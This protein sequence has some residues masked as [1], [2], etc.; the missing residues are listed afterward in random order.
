VALAVLVVMTDPQANPTAT[1]TG[2]PVQRFPIARLDLAEELRQL[3]ASPTTKSHLAKTVVHDAGLRVVLM[4]L[5]RGAKIPSHTADCSVMI[6]V[7]DGRVVVPLF[8]TSYDL[9]A[10]QLL[11]IDRNV[12]HAL[13]AIEDSALMLTVG[14]TDR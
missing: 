3:R 2:E 10:G 11:A 6:H 4:I 14:R 8:A 9:G 13:I 7:L 5:R 1:A 12:E